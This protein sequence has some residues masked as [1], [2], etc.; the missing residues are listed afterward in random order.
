MEGKTDNDKLLGSWRD[1]AGICLR[2]RGDLKLLVSLR[3][4]WAGKWDERTRGNFLTEMLVAYWVAG[5]E[6]E[7]AE[8]AKE[9]DSICGGG[10]GSTEKMLGRFLS[11][12][13]QGARGYAFICFRDYA[14]RL[15][16]DGVA[17]NNMAWLVATAK[18]DGLDH[19]GMD[20]WPATALAWAEQAKELSGG[21]VPGV[22][23]TLSAARANAGD[24][25]GAI[26]AAERALALAAESGDPALA[27]KLR[28]R[29][30]RYRAGAP[31][32]E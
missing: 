6:A 14:K 3:A 28:T 5:R 8:V 1:N 22:W 23:D 19:A 4:F 30:E 32:R 21:K 20:E 7:A 11:R 9:L 2:N 27:A 17:L 25:D 12:W 15:P 10:A 26:A 29:L 16:Q 18:P 24:F 31:W 13:Q